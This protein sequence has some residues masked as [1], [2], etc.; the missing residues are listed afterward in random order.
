M[1]RRDINFNFVPHPLTGDL[2]FKTG[3]SAVEQ[4]MK[5]LILTNYYERGFNVEVGSNLI[6]NLFDNFTPLIAQTM[7]DNVIQVLKNFEPNV[8]IVEVV[9]EQEESNTVNVEIYYNIFNDPE[10]RSVVI[11]IT[12]LR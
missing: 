2:T 6:D 1:A 11:P 12:R 7:K 5:N 9:V 8:E 3:K 4:S 10:I